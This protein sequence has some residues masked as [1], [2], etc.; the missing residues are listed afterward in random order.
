MDRWIVR[1]GRML[2]RMSFMVD[3]GIDCLYLL[4]VGTGLDDNSA[5]GKKESFGLSCNNNFVI[6]PFFFPLEYFAVHASITQLG[7]CN[8]K[9]ID[10]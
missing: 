9:D 10:H 1:V 2:L 7:P 6:F 3:S 5:W 4:A 8:R